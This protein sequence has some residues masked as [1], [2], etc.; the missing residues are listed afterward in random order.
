MITITALSVTTNALNDGILRVVRGATSGYVEEE[1]YIN[2]DTSFTAYTPVY[3]FDCD[4]IG[5]KYKNLKCDYTEA[6]LTITQYYWKSGLFY[7]SDKTLPAITA[8]GINGTP[9]VWYGYLWEDVEHLTS[10]EVPNIN[11]YEVA[12]DYTISTN[13]GKPIHNN[14][15]EWIKYSQD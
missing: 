14:A 8:T 6:T 5:F 3:I 10:G 2:S 15:G 12:T 11:G 7:P 9:D 13:E 4:N 1:T